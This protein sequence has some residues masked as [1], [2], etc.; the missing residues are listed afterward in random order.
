MDLDR[1][2]LEGQSYFQQGRK[3]GR[4][5]CHCQQGQLHGPYWYVR[6]LVSGQVR[7]LGKELPAE[8]A[9]ARAAHQ[10]LQDEMVRCRRAL[11][12]Q[13][14]A[15]EHLLQ[16]VA[17]TPVER[18]ILIGLQFEA[19]LVWPEPAAT[20]GGPAGTQARTLCQPE[21]RTLGPGTQDKVLGTANCGH[22][23]SGEWGA[24]VWLGG[25]S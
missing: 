7:Y 13:A 22:S 14:R 17:L 18:D 25:E 8:L 2:T 16:C 6:D 12:D 24:P 20:P 10:R 23:T 11:L 21:A 15:V 1:F 4:P 19:A 3:C 9:R 5:G